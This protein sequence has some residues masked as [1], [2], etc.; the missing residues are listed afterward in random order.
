VSAPRVYSAIAAVTADLAGTGIAKARVNQIDDYAYRSIDDVTNRLAPLLAKHRLCILPRVV[1]RTMGERAGPNHAL[2]L[3]VALKVGFDIVSARDGS[4]HTIMAYGEALD[5]GDK[6]TAKAMSAA[7]KQALLQAFCVPTSGAA[8]SDASTYKLKATGELSDPDQGWD[9]WSLDIQDMVR[10]CESEEALGR[11]Q[12]TYREQLRAAS[13]RRPE[14]Y[15]VIGDAVRV[16]REALASL[17]IRT[18]A[19]TVG[20]ACANGT[21]QA[22]AAHG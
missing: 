2:M 15:A 18:G 20:A 6:A 12:A 3:H 7:F 17:P 22:E 16:R 1:E 9:Q 13:K 21:A 11:V 19:R 10:V 14:I 4:M 5:G 8:D